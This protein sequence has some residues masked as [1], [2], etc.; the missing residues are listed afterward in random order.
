MLELYRWEESNTNIRIYLKIPHL[1]QLTNDRVKLRLRKSSIVVELNWP[2]KNGKAVSKIGPLFQ[3]IEKNA[4]QVNRKGELIILTLGK[5][6]KGKWR[7]LTKNKDDFPQ[8]NINP[9]QS[10]RQSRLENSRSRASRSKSRSR[11]RTP[12]NRSIVKAENPENNHISSIAT[13]KQT[14][15]KSSHSRSNLQKKSKKWSKKIANKYAHLPLMGLIHNKE[16]PVKVR[17]TNIRRMA[18]K[19]GILSK[20]SRSKVSNSQRSGIFSKLSHATG[21]SMG[22]TGKIQGFDKI[23]GKAL[24]DFKSQRVKTENF[25]EEKSDSKTYGT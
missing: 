25:H 22:K 16:T 1:D 18:Q 12:P 24:Q 21:Q 2:G 19:S 13:K 3:E 10:M 6:Y 8:K 20:S 5:K 15:F 14:Y 9:L 7:Q 11:S 17:P 23:L 4:F